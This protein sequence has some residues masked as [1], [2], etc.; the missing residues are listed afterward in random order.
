MTTSCFICLEQET[1]VPFKRLCQ[2]CLES[3]ICQKC[4]EEALHNTTNP[5]VL[6]N[7]PICRRRVLNNV[8]VDRLVLIS[9]WQPIIFIIWW[10]YGLTAPLWQQ[11]LVLFMTN[12]LLSGLVRRIN[13][14][15]DNDRPSMFIRK[16][17]LL[18]VI[19]HAPY[20]MLISFF[21]HRPLDPDLA[22]NTY[23]LSHL[24]FPASLYFLGKILQIL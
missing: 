24:G 21:D 8:V 13:S 23:I 5:D 19:I 20:L 6:T 22:F 2:T 10:L 14:K 9:H 3:T 18:N 12:V 15:I 4:E 17:K 11:I 1:R 16:F 7:C